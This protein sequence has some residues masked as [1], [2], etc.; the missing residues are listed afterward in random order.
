MTPCTKLRM[1]ATYT[2]DESIGLVETIRSHGEVWSNLERF[3]RSAVCVYQMPK[4]GIML[5]GHQSQ[6]ERCSTM[7]TWHTKPQRLVLDQGKEQSTCED[8]RRS[9]VEI[10]RRTGVRV[11]PGFELDNSRPRRSP[12]CGSKLDDSP[13]DEDEEI[14]SANG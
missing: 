3:R 10:A 6:I 5:E 1:F 14:A 11:P 4:E 9:A 12:Q 7:H 2:K 8:L 13:A